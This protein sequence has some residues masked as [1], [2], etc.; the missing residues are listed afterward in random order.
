MKSTPQAP[1][2]LAEPTRN[3]WRSVIKAYQLEPHHLRLLQLAGESWDRSQE[4]RMILAKD[5]V[6]VT[7]DRGNVRAHP[8]VAIERD[9]RIAFARL[10][11]ELDLDTEPPSSD[12]VAPVGLRS[13]RRGGGYAG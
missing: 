10:V 3:W 11:R 7:D 4:A 13:N 9:S 1:S 5:G 12:R 8:A 6:V 2:H